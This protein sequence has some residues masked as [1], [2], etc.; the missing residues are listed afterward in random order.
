MKLFFR[1][2]IPLILLT[3]VQLTVVTTVFYLDGYR[4]WTVA[5][6][7]ISL[8]IC[9]FVVYLIYRYISHRK[10]YQLLSKKE[11]KLEE[12]YQLGEQSP[13]PV[14]VNEL[15][16]SQYRHYENAMVEG[17]RNW[18][19]HITFMN[20]WVHQMK[21]PLS[22]LELMLQED[23]EPRNESM[24]EETERLRTGLEMILYMA[25]LETFEHDFV[26]DK[27]VLR[28]LANEV[29][30]EN[31]RLF[32]RNYVY[33]RIEIEK[34][35][36]VETDRKWL[37]FILLQLISN[38][39]KFAS[40]T[41]T[42]ITIAAYAN[43]RGVYLEVRDQGVGIPSSDMKR[44][45]QPFF[46]GENGRRFKESSG[47]GLYI[48]KTVMDK[49]NQGIEAESEVGRSTVIRLIFPYARAGKARD[50]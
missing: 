15:L 14:S 35:L 22:V 16:Q 18:Q 28:E 26:V 32:I 9:V 34:D 20:Q 11:F 12:S 50:R 13:L 33:P 43:D 44:I 7:A 24:L 6:Y 5:A 42:Q 39:V 37:R 46:T 45:F 41:E 8:G 38:A 25:R 1:E 17:E 4:N 30:L 3:L 23:D 2:H 49:M 19:N 29:I 10:F 27:V 40:G 31:K 47:M 21:T 36:I 48:A